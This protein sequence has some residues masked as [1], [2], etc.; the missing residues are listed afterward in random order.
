MD[1]IIEDSIPDDME[2]DNSVDDHLTDAEK[3]DEMQQWAIQRENAVLQFESIIE[4]VKKTLAGKDVEIITVADVSG[5]MTQCKK[6]P[7]GRR[8][9][10]GHHFGHGTGF[11]VSIREEGVDLREQVQNQLYHCIR[12]QEDRPF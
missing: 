12:R 1:T 2:C 3:A 6:C 11:I 9:L 10:H 5:S 8:G 7:D 4:S